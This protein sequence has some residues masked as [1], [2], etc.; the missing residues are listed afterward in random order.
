MVRASAE[1]M[2]ISSLLNTG[3][4]KSPRAHGIRPD[5]LSGYREE[6]EWLLSFCTR[7]GSMPS[8]EKLKMVFPDFPFAQDE[9]DPRWSASEVYEHYAKRSLMAAIMKSGT[10]LEHNEVREAYSLFE[11]MRYAEV[12]N[13]PDNLLVDPGYLD[14]YTSDEDYRLATPWRS[15]TDLTGGIGAGELWYWLARLGQG[16]S[17]MLINIAVDVA[18]KGHRV[19]F[20]GLEM[21]KRQIQVRAHAIMGQRLGWGDQVDAKAML[22]RDYD[23]KLYKKLLDEIDENVPG[24]L[25]IH[26]LSLGSV[27]PSVINAHAGD[28]DLI[29]VD[30]VGLMR[31]DT[32]S[33]AIEDWRAAAIISNAL[34]EI[35]GAHR[36]R[37]LAAAQINRDGE[38]DRFKPPDL[39]NAAQTDSIGQDADVAVTMKK[40]SRNSVICRLVKNRNGEDDRLFWTRYRPNTGDYSEVTADQADQIRDDDE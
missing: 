30:H 7:F 8:V 36:A 31:T 6:F 12:T 37:I 17:S 5:M 21:T 10:L 27:S 35:T 9:V 32:G 16:K 39:K 4:P 24:E 2:L 23:P 14:D 15:L 25:H 20:Y 22:Y 38:S 18:C 1:S 19:M 13:R 11:G 34:K 33:R 26:D 40:Y 3:D 29:V 28:Y